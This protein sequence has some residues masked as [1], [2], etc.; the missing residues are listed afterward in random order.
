MCI[1]DRPSDLPK[2]RETLDSVMPSPK[3]PVVEK[4]TVEN[5]VVDDEQQPVE[6]RESLKDVTPQI[7]Q[8]NTQQNVE[9]DSSSEL[10]MEKLLGEATGRNASDL[11]IS[12]GY[13]PIIRID[14]ELV[15]LEESILNPCLLYTS[16]CV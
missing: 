2:F 14:G 4:E 3:E 11:H 10:T 13:P 12:V 7:Q 9:F 1:R 8:E 16:R 6:E 15:A 5:E